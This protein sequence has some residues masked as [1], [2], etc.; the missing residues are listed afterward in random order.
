M[1]SARRE[2]LIGRS[3]SGSH[4]L[5][6]DSS[7]AKYGGGTVLPH[8][9]TARLWS[10]GS[11]AALQ[12]ICVVPLWVKGFVLGNRRERY[13][14]LCCAC[15]ATRLARYLALLSSL[16][17]FCHPERHHSS[18]QRARA[19]PLNLVGANAARHFGGIDNSVG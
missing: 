5:T 6:V 17:I 7:L 18:A 19:L 12:H 14:A 16:W 1:T 2:P 3:A 8:E 4:E 11:L 10:S 15:P 13:E 9:V